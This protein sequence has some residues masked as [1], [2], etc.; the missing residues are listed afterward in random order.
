METV[1]TTQTPEASVVIRKTSNFLIP[2]KIA[3]NGR[4]NTLSGDALRMYIHIAYTLFRRHTQDCM[5]SDFELTLCLG[6]PKPYVHATR[7]E[8]HAHTLIDFVLTKNGAL[9]QLADEELSTPRH[10]P[11]TE[12]VVIHSHN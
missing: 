5:C 3:K 1:Q 11:Q 9:Y 8:L 2:R 6:I 12:F 7:C 10:K 4:L